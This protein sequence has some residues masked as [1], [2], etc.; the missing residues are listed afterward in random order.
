MKRSSL[1]LISLIVMVSFFCMPSAN[2]QIV[3]VTDGTCTD[4]DQECNGQANDGCNSQN[5]T[6]P[7]NGDYLL[8]VAIDQCGGSVACQHC[9]SEAYLGGGDVSVCIHT[10]CCS[11]QSQPI[12]LRVNTTY[13]LY[14]CKINCGG[15]D[16]DDCGTACTA[17]ATVDGPSDK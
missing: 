7:E 10:G 5:F 8:K 2:G 4:V 1:V 17:R 15:Y 14:C 16:C 12:A 11:A 9:V 3:M 13:T 6:V